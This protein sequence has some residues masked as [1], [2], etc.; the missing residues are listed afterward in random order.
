MRRIHP[1]VVGCVLLVG[2]WAWLTLGIDLSIVPSSGEICNE[3]ANTKEKECASHHIALFFFLK[4]TKFFEEHN[5]AITAFSTIIIAAFTWRLWWATDRLWSE[6]KGASVIAGTA[7]KAATDTVVHMRD[8]AAMELR[9]YVLVKKIEIASGPSI[10]F[11]KR[12][13]HLL[14]SLINFGKIPA[15]N[16]LLRYTIIPGHPIR[17][18]PPSL[19]MDC[20]GG[21]L[22]PSDEFTMRVRLSEEMH[23]SFLAFE[24]TLHAVGEISYNDGFHDGKITRF[25]FKRIGKKWTIEG[26]F[27]VNDHG[28]DY[29]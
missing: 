23:I 4:A 11:A 18:A 9:A 12:E 13:P 8:S 15:R 3:V 17:M 16:L 22:A 26:E 20:N 27:D 28:N 2:A 19:D 5:G 7:A 25:W 14:V 21:V 29:T 1:A 24:N 10:L 6:A